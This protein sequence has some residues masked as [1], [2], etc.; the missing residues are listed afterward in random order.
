MKSAFTAGIRGW[1]AAS[2]AL[3]ASV[4]VSQVKVTTYHN[5][6]L[7]TGLNAQETILKPSNVSASNFGLLFTLPVDGQVYA[8][9]LYLSGV[10]VPGKGTHNVVYIATEHNS[11]YAFDA[12]SNQ[13]VN[14]QPLWHVNFGPTVP[15]GDT[16]S[17]DITNEIGITS[18]R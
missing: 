18:T 15:Q 1:I 14:A 5:D 13:G 6:N 2:C 7:R 8:Q 11:L 3:L 9:P 4:A 12:D 17:D 16:G 10:S